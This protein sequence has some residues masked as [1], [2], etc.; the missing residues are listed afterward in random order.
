MKHGDIGSQIIVYFMDDLV[1]TCTLI[2]CCLI[3][4]LLGSLSED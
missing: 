2:F 3:V 1:V 4:H